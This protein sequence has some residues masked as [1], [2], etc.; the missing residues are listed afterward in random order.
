MVNSVNMNP[1]KWNHQSWRKFFAVSALWN[2]FGSIPAIVFPKLNMLLFYG[3]RT[4]DYYAL[5]FNRGLW[6]VVFIFGIGYLLVSVN[7][8]RFT[9]IIIMGIIGKV[10]VIGTWF[11]MYS[12]E[13]ATGLAIFGATGD[14]LFTLLF[15]LFLIRGPASGPDG[16]A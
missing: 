4:E 9:G 1:F 14:S 10:T 16:T 8:M 13:R 11:Y 6:V 5:F 3:E 15:I 7:P 12:I 2:F